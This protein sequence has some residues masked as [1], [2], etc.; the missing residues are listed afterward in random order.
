ML[1]SFLLRRGYHMS[2][3]TR[4][5]RFTILMTTLSAELPGLLATR[6]LALRGSERATVDNAGSSFGDSCGL[7]YKVGGSLGSSLGPPYGAGNALGDSLALRYGAGNALSD[8]LGLS[9]IAGNALGDSLILSYGAGNALAA[10]LGLTYRACGSLGDAFG[11]SY[12]AGDPLGNAFGSS[13]RRLRDLSSSTSLPLGSRR[14]AA[15][16]KKY[17]CTTNFCATPLATMV[18][19]WLK[20]ALRSSPLRPSYSAPV[21][22]FWA[23]LWTVEKMLSCARSRTSA[24]TALPVST[25]AFT[26]PS[27]SSGACIVAS[28]PS[29]SRVSSRRSGVDTCSLAFAVWK[30]Y[31]AAVATTLLTAASRKTTAGPIF[32]SSTSPSPNAPVRFC[33]RLATP[34]SRSRLTKKVMPGFSDSTR[35][36]S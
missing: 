26:A 17:S 8:S 33:S 31:V 35:L 32:G 16:M 9:Y 18:I 20:K 5:F 27:L 13:C 1:R 3:T 12:R 28:S 11:P 22:S 10:S 34:F 6:L 14:S 15:I 4:W 25:A 2:S 24:T 36:A 21:P 29:G 23:I 30:G 19:P 7:R